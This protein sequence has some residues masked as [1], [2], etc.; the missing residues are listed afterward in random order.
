MLV[1]QI[2]IYRLRCKKV[3]NGEVYAIP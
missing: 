2:V 1:V 3:I